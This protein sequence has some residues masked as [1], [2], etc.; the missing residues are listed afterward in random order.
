MSSLLPVFQG[1]SLTLGLIMA[2]GAQNAML[3][4]Q[5][6][7]NQHQWL[8]AAICIVI[9]VALIVAGVFG[10]SLLLQQ[11]PQLLLWFKW[12][13]ALF[14]AWYGFTA[15]RQIRKNHH[16]QTG[17]AVASARRAI[18]LAT[19]AVSLLNPHV[20]LD[21]VI[22]VGSVGAQLPAVE[23]FW[24]VLGASAAS[25]TWFVSLCVAGRLLQP[26]FQKPRAWQVL[27]GLV[28]S[29]MWAIALSLVL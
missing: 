13:G 17:D 4:A 29:T 20:Y 28:G 14:L 15:F 25:A 5:S 11:A 24:F 9:D 26:V 1:Y 21:T 18:I 7:K 27:H 16:L 19:L 12:G 8:M 10:L 3:L 2:I 22:L 6:L 23:R